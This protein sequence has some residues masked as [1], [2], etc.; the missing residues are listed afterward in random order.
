VKFGDIEAEARTP[1][2]IEEL[3]KRVSDFRQNERD[4]DN[5]RS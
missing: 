3:L 5:D 4:A 1:A 2:E